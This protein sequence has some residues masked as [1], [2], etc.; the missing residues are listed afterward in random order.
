MDVRPL[1]RWVLRLRDYRRIAGRDWWALAGASRPGVTQRR[2]V[3]LRGPHGQVTFRVGTSDPDVVWS[4]LALPTHLPTKI[5]PSAIWDLGANIGLTAADLGRRYPEARVVALEPDPGNAA[6]ARQNTSA[7]ANCEVIESAAW[8]ESGTLSFLA[9]PG[10]EA[11]S[12]VHPEGTSAVAATSL[13]DL[14]ARTFPPDFVKMDVEGAERSLLTQATE[15]VASVMEIRV[16]CHGDYLSQ[17]VEDLGRLGFE[18]KV[19]AERWARDSVI[20]WR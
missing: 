14:V 16:E 13:N 1:A 5:E 17:C 2:L 11:G 4:S 6:L 8:T 3:T 18:S 7:Y 15:W 19:V 10:R 20:G 9:E 12:R